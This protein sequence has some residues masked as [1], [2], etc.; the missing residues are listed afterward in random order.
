MKHKGVLPI[1]FLILIVAGVVS[2]FSVFADR[3]PRAAVTGSSPLQMQT[4]EQ[5]RM[6]VI[7]FR[8][9]SW[10]SDVIP[11]G[12][13]PVKAN[14]PSHP[15]PKPTKASPRCGRPGRIELCTYHSGKNSTRY[16]PG[17]HNLN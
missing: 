6:A 9:L 2:L 4:V 7:Y 11:R 10:L 1:P 15:A 12:G 14:P 8:V 17:T 3:Q 13:D 16:N 5:E